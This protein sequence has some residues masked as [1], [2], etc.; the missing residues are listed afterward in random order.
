M[1]SLRASSIPGSPAAAI[2]VRHAL[3]S[4]YIILQINLEAVICNLSPPPP[5]A[6]PQARVEDGV[7]GYKDLA[8]LPRDKAI[9]DIE[10]PDLMVYQPHYSYSPVEVC[11]CLSVCHEHAQQVLLVMVKKLQDSKTCFTRIF[12][13]NQRSKERREE[14]RREETRRRIRKLLSSV[15]AKLS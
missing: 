9:L 5:L 10:R 13:E 8:A 6:A 3:R 15:Y 4:C 11:V 14:T 2:V 12:I 7:I 1:L